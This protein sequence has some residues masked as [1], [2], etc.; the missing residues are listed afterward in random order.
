MSDTYTA[1]LIDAAEERATAYDGDDRDC[2]KTDVINA[3]FAGSAFHAQDTAWPAD[4][5]APARTQYPALFRPVDGGRYL[6]TFRDVPEALTQADDEAGALE[7]AEAALATALDFYFEDD[8][9]P[10]L[11][12][13]LQPGE[14]LVTLPLESDLLLT[15]RTLAALREAASS[16]AVWWTMIEAQEELATGDLTTN[17]PDNKVVLH[18][19]G[20]GASTMVTAGQL[21]GLMTATGNA[22]GLLATPA[23]RAE[24]ARMRQAYEDGAQHDDKRADD[25]GI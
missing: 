14:R 16:V 11:P 20:S 4:M 9:L 2:I 3:F 24:Y 22:A 1:R 21:R 12:S 23:D 13:A 25:D 19:M 15:Q 7:M 10:A 5:T 8:R 18:F 17:L 6:V